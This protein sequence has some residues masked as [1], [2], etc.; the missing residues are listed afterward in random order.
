MARTDGGMTDERRPEDA[1]APDDGRPLPG[2]DGPAPAGDP[3]MPTTPDPVP[4]DPPMPTPPDA[5]VPVAADP[6]MPGMREVP[7]AVAIPRPPVVPERAAPRPP[8][9]WA[10]P[11]SRMDGGAAAP[12]MGAALLRVGLALLI[13][14]AGIAAGM[15]YWQVVRADDLT[16]DPRNP[17]VQAATRTA[18]RGRILAADGE[19]VADNAGTPGDRLRVYPEP[20][21]AAV[22]GYQSLLFG[23]SGIERAYDGEL[24][25][26]RPLGPGGE[27]LRKFLSD[28]YDPSDVH[29]SVDLEL[30][31][32][33]M[34]ALGGRRGAV[35]AI[36]PAT[37]RVLT[38]A[39]TPTFDPQRLVD[40]ESGR[41]Y[42]EDLRA[43]RAAPLLNRATQGLFV[44]GS[45][46]KIVTAAA[47]LGSGT[48][49]PD[50][51]YPT[52][53]EYRTGFTVQG[54]TIRDAPRSVQTDH[55]LDFHEGLEV[56]SNIW[57]AH[58]GLDA[59]PEELQAWAARFGFGSPVPFELP[60]AASQVTGG[61]GP[62]AGFAD[63]VELAN[64][65][66]GQ[67][68]TLVTP[69]QMALVAC[70]VANDGLI[71]RP[72]LV[73]RLVAESGGTQDVPSEV[74]G[75]SMNAPLADVIGEGMVRAVEGEFGE[76]FA[77]G[78]K[79]PGVTTAGKSG[80]GQ[81]G[82]T[83]RPHSWFIGYAPAEAPRIAIAVIVERA[84]FG[85]QVAVPMA[86]DL[87][88]LY[89]SGE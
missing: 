81:V 89:L 80:S 27:V 70:A 78:A 45:V 5:P 11:A 22:V 72:R 57:F 24:T 34:A 42:L 43:Q 88:E 32:A 8:G 16:T 53:E 56:S 7:A 18:P 4:A 3:P 69:L 79:V 31:R 1:A 48:V 85:S 13:A 65:A 55:P 64:A 40:P 74:L 59:G 36:E 14:F 39:S 86:G 38:L 29:L 26:L 12:D 20:A 62:L 87:M 50:T 71:M 41:A 37:G 51:R 15:G 77:G 6:P 66:Y 2:D 30:Q 75:R 83:G 28:P 19:I 82:D 76:G 47:A 9:R 33:A 84:G 46:F 54:F 60:T 67:G 17:L 58:A 35:V 68:E 25:G 63:Q 44:P 52:D 23:T 21:M 73:D 49:S 61:D 10:E